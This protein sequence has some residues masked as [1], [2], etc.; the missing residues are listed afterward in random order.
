MTNITLP[1]KFN[2]KTRPY[3]LEILS[4]KAKNK[5]LVLHRRAGKTALAIN[6]LIMQ[7]FLP[8]NKGKTFWYIAPSYRQGKEVVW[9]DPNMLF[10][11]LP[12]EL[13]LK[14]NEQA[15]S[16]KTVNNTRIVVKGGDDP[17]SLLGAD[18]YGIVMDETQSQKPEVYERVLRPIL[19][20]NGGW[21]WFLGTPRFKDHFHRHAVYA[22]RREGWQYYHLGADTSGII[23]DEELAEIQAQTPIDLFR[24]EYLAHFLDG[25]GAIFRNVQEVCTGAMEGPK[26]GH[27]YTIGVDLARKMDF[28][29]ITVYDQSQSKVVYIERFNNV[30]WAF[31]RAKIEVVA[32]KYASLGKPSRVVMDST[33]VGDPICQDLRNEGLWIQSV[34]FTNKVK[35]EMIRALQIKFDHKE[36]VCPRFSPLVDELEIFQATKSQFG[37]FRYGAPAK[38][39]DDCVF[40]LGLAVWRSPFIAKKGEKSK[41]SLLMGKYKKKN[42]YAPKAKKLANL[43]D[44]S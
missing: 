11:F 17:D 14:R 40:S 30:D 38:M 44:L 39:H 27:T 1:H 12:K 32:R 19:A 4:N 16:I 18:P 7:A 15:L 20:A 36:I 10:K 23:D 6:Q 25:D 24:Q 28:T 33:G 29:V 31:Q 26:Y 13:I 37:N 21:I 9:D 3:Q 22:K 5:V 34:T 2:P 43:M 35:E 8:E 42:R 41:R